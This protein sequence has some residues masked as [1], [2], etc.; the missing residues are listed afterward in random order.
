MKRL[1]LLLFSGWVAAAQADAPL[2]GDI[3]RDLN[4][5]QGSLA[6]AQG[7][8][9]LESVVERALRQAERLE[10]GNRSDQW[11]SALYYQLAAGA[12]SRQGDTGAAA[13]RLASARARSSV[14]G[15]QA[16]RWL[17][18]EA[19]LRRAAGQ[20]T[21]AITLY[22]QWLKNGSDADMS[23]QLVRLLADDDQWDAAAE[24]LSSLL[25][26]SEPTTEARQ[27]L[28]LNVM[29]RAGQ[30]EQALGWLL[31]GLDE[32][33]SSDE[34]R[35]AAGLAQQ[36]GQADVAA[37]LWETAW[38]LGKFESDE[39][40]ETLIQLHFA[41]GTPARAAEHLQAALDGERLA[42]SEATLRRV[43]AAWSQAKDR[44]QA[45]DAWQ[46]LAEQSGK[47]EHWRRYGQLAYAW[48]DEARAERAWQQAQA[49]GDEEVDAWLASLH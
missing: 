34:W 17:R 33:S 3:I 28:A 41:G 12:L 26:Q 1:A 22:Q 37:G 30:G 6:S 16:R 13:D 35:Q 40:F 36:A 27:A 43:A 8:Q 2:S 20:R 4:A 45:L 38:Q 19:Q 49:L 32:E 10:S 24:R 46:A 14:G 42:R 7:E 11:A 47:A 29:R 31:E 48:N 21:R 15:E 5:L 18:E 44:E 23:W 9:A 25:E 39:D